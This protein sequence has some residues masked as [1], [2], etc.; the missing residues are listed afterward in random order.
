MIGYNWLGS[1]AVTLGSL[2]LSTLLPAAFA[3]NTTIPSSSMTFGDDVKLAV[4]VPEGSAKTDLYFTFEAP[5]KDHTWAGFGMGTRMHDSLIFVVYRSADNQ[6]EPTLSP[7]LGEQHSMPLF[8][9]QVNTSILEG[10]TVTD[11]RFV[12]NFHCVGCRSWDGG[13]VDV[14]S[15][16]APFFY[17]LGPEGSL[18]SDDKEV[19]INRH[20]AHSVI[21]PLDMKAA[22][23]ANGVP[24]IGS[25][26]D[27]NPTGAADDDSG[28][29]SG[30]GISR[31]VA[32][33]GFVMCFAFA[34][35]FPGGYL[36][37]RIFE[38][39][40]LHWGIQ[41]FG[42][43][44]VFLGVASGIAVSIREQLSPKLTHPHQIIGLLTFIVVLA[45][46]TLGLIGHMMFKRKG[47]PSPLMKVHRIVG[48]SS[49]LLGFINACTGLA[50]V[51]IPRA[52][53]GYTIFNLLVVIVVAS[54][55]MLKKKRK[56]RREAMNSNAAHNFR[57][58]MPAYSHVRGGST[59]QHGPADFAAPPP[60]YGQ[61]VPLQTFGQ[62]PLRQGPTEYYNVQ[63][64]K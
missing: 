25:A 51:G 49:I 34:L 37:L 15:T 16:D 39:V 64:N 61:S 44:L 14:A 2:L 52:I 30:I 10:S 45:A 58:G 50:W 53:I 4:N 29:A 13:E 54:L 60:A 26:T 17:A 48:P 63:P 19:Q 57:E 35:V 47:I 9:T 5:A 23:G 56:M 3:E 42:L 21:F 40:W 28:S 46:W 7:R 12:V 32:I 20:E 31:G 6:G 41:S 36:F 22:T 8:T 11:D 27:G 18:Q 62:Q 43:L 59:Q 33:H 38:R 24:G 1:S 55:V